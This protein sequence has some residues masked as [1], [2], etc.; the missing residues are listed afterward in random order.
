MTTDSGFNRRFI[1]TAIIIA[2]GCA[3][4][5]LTSLVEYRGDDLAYA[6]GLNNYISQT[7]HSA[8]R[9]PLS[10]IMSVNGR[11]GD[12]F[13]FILFDFI[14]RSVLNIICGCAVALFYWMILS[15]GLSDKI[16]VTGRIIVIALVTFTFQ[17]WDLFLMLVVQINYIWATSLN[18]LCVFLILKKN[19]SRKE[20]IALIPLFFISPAM[21]EAC[22][23]PIAVSGLL[24]CMVHK[25]SLKGILKSNKGPLFISYALGMF[26]PFLSPAFYGR[27]FSSIS[28]TTP[29]DSPLMIF[30]KSDYYVLIL[31]CI[32]IL[33]VACKKMN[34]REIIFSPTFFWICAGVVSSLISAVSG[35]VGRSGWFAQTFAVIAILQLISQIDFNIKVFSGIV[36]S[37]A[38]T[39][40][41]SIHFYALISWQTLYY[42]MTR[43]ILTEYHKHP[44]KPIFINYIYFNDSPWW[45]LN[46][47]LGMFDPS[48]RYALETERWV[49][50]IPSNTPLLLLPAE[51]KN[52]DLYKISLPYASHNFKLY[53]TTGMKEDTMPTIKNGVEYMKFPLKI[54]DRDMI[55]ERKRDMRPGDR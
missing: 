54:K 18:L 53:Y 17:W 37:A 43:E 3:Y 36:I 23:F 55:I 4:V 41:M 8:W 49:H 25:R 30:L 44:G 34:L 13:N 22:G 40:L 39:I 24:W 10:H 29:D 28:V 7:G 48:D 47:H 35:V 16:G 12:T 26:I 46:K 33:F 31:I 2:I 51:L 9:Y 42:K 20:A 52:I 27:V 38:L 50:N 45:L 14:P 19:Y 11:L 1:A 32:I 15:L 6:N 5:W 21:H